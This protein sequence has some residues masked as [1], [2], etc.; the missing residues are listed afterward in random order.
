MSGQDV[1]TKE[2][3]VDP[4][5][6]MSVLHEKAA[7]HLEFEGKTYFFCHMNCKNKFEKAPQ[8]Y[9]DT[10]SA[11]SKKSMNT[12]SPSSST[13]V[14]SEKGIAQVSAFYLPG[15]AVEYFCPMDLQ[16]RQANPG[17]CPLCGMALEPTFVTD[18]ANDSGKELKDLTLR[19]TIAIP[20]TILLVSISMNAMFQMETFHSLAGVPIQYI[21]LALATPVLFYS[22][23]PI[24]KKG[25]D[26]FGS[27]YMNMFT[28][29]ALGSSISYFASVFFLCFPNL[30]RASIHEL[31]F[32]ESSAS[33]V[34][35]VLIGQVLELK[36]RQRGRSA[37]QDLLLLAPSTARQMQPDGTFKEI[38]V[39]TIQ[40][41]DK[42]QVLAGDKIPV[43]GAVLSGNASINEA[44]ITGNNLPATKTKESIV[45]AGTVA[46]DGSIVIE[47]RS[48]GRDTVFAHILAT[49][50][51]AQSSQSP[52]QSLADKISAYFIP[53][54]MIVAALTFLGWYFLGAGTGIAK[55]VLNSISV[56]V[57]ACP[58]ALGLATPLAVSAAIARG[59]NSGLLVKDSRALEMLA[60]V[61]DALFDKTGTLSQGQFKIRSIKTFNTSENEALKIAGSLEALSK[62]PLAVC[63]YKEARDRSLDLVEAHNSSVRPGLGISGDLNGTRTLLGSKRFLQESGVDLSKL[64]HEPDQDSEQNQPAKADAKPE[65]TADAAINA[66]LHTMTHADTYSN[67]A[68]GS[69]VYLAINN[70]LAALFVLE[71]PL[72][73]EAAQTLSELRQLGVNPKIASGDNEA[74]VASAAKALGLSDG[75]LNYNL[76]PEGKVE[77]IKRLQASGSKVAMIGD[78]IND[79]AALSIADAG[80][81]MASG[82]DIALSSAP[83]TAMH[84]DLTVIPKAIKLARLMTS[85]MKE[86][87]FLA[88]IYNV[89]AIICASGLLSPLGIN[90]TPSIAAAAMSLSSLS[91]IANSSKIRNAKL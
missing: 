84:S 3:S 25:M 43:D 5:C 10:A 77:L 1:E 63:I 67:E 37:T 32:F 72:R 75:D 23:W 57:I 68:G 36:A 47:A 21:E 51:S 78:G 73:T 34:T 19:L 18:S 24:L 76:L 70:Q 11:F 86:N 20:L 59:A 38:S 85:T 87:L 40:P 27:G 39:T 91:V 29:L 89:I 8:K 30:I 46:N 81:A 42:I 49:L 12:S 60:T 62:H 50:S 16:I 64:E 61:N 17:A 35:L 66:K 56:L 83:L 2:I 6:G 45:Y 7:A 65:T 33:I 74:S 53:I 28:L 90:L 4:V 14:G 41:G 58:C 31:L 48:L 79:S 71:D 54:V 80:I 69:L 13:S 26:S 55:A 9:L 52:T 88:F 44:L 15:G 82:S 22:G